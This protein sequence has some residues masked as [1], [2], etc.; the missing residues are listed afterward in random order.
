M[1]KIRPHATIQYLM[2]INQKILTCAGDD[3]RKAMKKNN[4]CFGQLF[5]KEYEPGTIKS[6]PHLHIVTTDRIS[7]I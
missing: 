5:F 3:P 2:T 1:A 7:I 6:E 4:L